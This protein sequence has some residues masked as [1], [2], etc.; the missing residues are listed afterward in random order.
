MEPPRLEYVFQITIELSARLRY[1][2][3]TDGLE[4]GHVGVTGGTVRGPRL[5][6]RIV[7]HSGGDW[8]SIR[9]DLT[10]DFNARYLIEADDGTLIQ[11]RNTGIRHGPREVLE[12]LQRYEPVDPSEY[13]MRVTPRFDAPEGPHGWLSRTIFIGQTNR[14]KERSIFDY[15]A[16]L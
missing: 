2:P 10:C 9:P 11:I 13:Y 4:R 16:V 15:W 1:G 5:N 12:R 6:G 8:P 7:P 3:T 14:Q